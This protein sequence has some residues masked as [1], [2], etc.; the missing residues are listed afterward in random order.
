MS[1][2]KSFRIFKG[3]LPV[4]A[5]V[6]FTCIVRCGERKFKDMPYRQKSREYRK[7]LNPRKLY[8]NKRLKLFLRRRVGVINEGSGAAIARPSKR[9]DE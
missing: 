8:A 2:S 4:R 3:R 1:E 5:Q 9:R 6:I 7:R